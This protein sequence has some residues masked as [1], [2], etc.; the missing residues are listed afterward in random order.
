MKNFFRFAVLAPLFLFTALAGGQVPK[1]DFNRARTVDVENYTIRTSFDR[2]RKM[3]FGDTTVT[4]K[5]LSDGFTTLELDARGMTFQSVELERESASLKFRVTDQSVVVELDRPRRSG[6]TV[7][8]RFKYSAKPA[9]GIYFVDA[10]RDGKGPARDAQIWTQG[11]PEEARYWIPSYDFPDDK[12]TSEQFITVDAGET[13]IA[14]GELVGVSEEGKKKTFH[15]R[16]T[17]PHSTYL[18]SF[19]VGNFVKL[20]G[21]HRNVPLG[22]YVYP[23][24]EA[25]ARKA[26]PQTAEMMRVFEEITGIDYPFAKYDQTIVGNFNFGGMENVTATTLS[27]EEVFLIEQSFGKNIVEDLIS[28]ELAHSWFGNLVTCRNWAELWLNESFATF[29]EA[30]YRERKYGR[31]DYL[32]K[33]QED[34]DEYFAEN[35]RLKRKRGLFNQLARP[36]DSI[37]DTV[38]Y[39]KGGAVLHTLR[40]E[41]GDAVFWRAVREYL[42]R[43]KWKNV[44]TTDLKKVFEEVSGRDLTRFFEQWVYGARHP[45]IRYARAYDPATGKLTIDI[46]Q[47]QI[48][49]EMSP[50]P[51]EL[52][53]EIEINV[54]GV[55]KKETLRIDKRVQSFTLATDSKPGK[56][57][58][59]PSRKLPLVQIRER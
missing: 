43:F 12:A 2:R 49:D 58:F 23:G 28:H 18:I 45:I 36:D 7:R 4:F 44:E 1:P 57:V 41:V 32:R 47:T 26:F 22:Y 6:E 30:V 8:I 55:W 54:G 16:M 29:M 15:F 19:V 31:S 24:T 14:N 11:E 46:E 5:P 38:T 9:K 37:F 59:D 25:I 48:E 21:S 53:L 27:D 13:A 40:E 56:I 10:A 34:A 20:S 42:R 51:F 3:V 33:I 35:A 50:L 17:Q 52:A 39:Q